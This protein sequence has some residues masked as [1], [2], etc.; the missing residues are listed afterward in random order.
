MNISW[1]RDRPIH[2]TQTANTHAFKISRSTAEPFAVASTTSINSSRVSAPFF[3]FDFFLR[4]SSRRFKKSPELSG[5]GRVVP[6][7]GCSW[8]SSISEMR[9]SIFS[10]DET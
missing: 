7:R 9:S 6:G 8:R 1:V 4:A 3:S 10:G 5:S 2:R